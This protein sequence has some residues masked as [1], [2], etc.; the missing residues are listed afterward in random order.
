MTRKDHEAPLSLLGYTLLSLLARATLSGYDL[1]REMRKPHT[2]FYGQGHVSQ[3]YPELARLEA[4]GLVTVRTVEQQ[5]RPDKKLYALSNEGLAKLRAW[6]VEPTPMTEPRSAFLIKAHSLWLAD[7]AL[8]LLQFR[9]RELY[10]QSLL[11]A[12]EADLAELETQYGDAI[13][14]LEGARF[15]DY[16]TLKRGVSYEHEHLA[17]LRWVITLLERRMS[18]NADI[19]QDIER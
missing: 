10:H 3:I 7:P 5:S 16:L 18:E 11:E 14:T 4:A 9:E 19:A 1:A 2:F 13:A 17:W 6:L 15:G 12:Y 8:A